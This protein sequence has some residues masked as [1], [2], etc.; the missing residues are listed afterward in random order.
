MKIYC[1]KEYIQGVCTRTMHI[2]T[3]KVAYNSRKEDS[4][5]SEWNKLFPRA[6]SLFA[7]FEAIDLHWE[8]CVPPF[9]SLAVFPLSVFSKVQRC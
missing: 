7:F 6:N 8:Y 4:K 5:L 2:K 9:P 1:L 3:R